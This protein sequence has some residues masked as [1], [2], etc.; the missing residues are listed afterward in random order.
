MGAQLD[1]MFNKDDTATTQQMKRGE[2]KRKVAR[3]YARLVT[4][5]ERKL[6]IAIYGEF[7]LRIPTGKKAP[8]NKTPTLSKNLTLF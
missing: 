3:N 5:P 4:P 1:V 2:L 7:N 8:S 6:W